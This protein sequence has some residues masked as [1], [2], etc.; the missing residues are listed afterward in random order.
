[1]YLDRVIACP[2]VGRQSSCTVMMMMVLYFFFVRRHNEVGTS[3]VVLISTACTRLVA[4]ASFATDL[5][6]YFLCR[7]A[8][9]S[10]FGLYLVRRRGAYYREQGGGRP[11][12]H[13][14]GSQIMDLS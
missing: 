2:L 5:F 14:Q 8:G 13:S 12:D 9:Q 3:T 7:Y 10:V 1:M 11:E 4:S 6:A